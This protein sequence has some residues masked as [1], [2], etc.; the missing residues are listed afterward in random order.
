MFGKVIP[1]FG[2]LLFASVVGIASGV[3][4][5]QPWYFV[6][7][8]QKNRNNVEDAADSEQTSILDEEEVI[9]CNLD[10]STDK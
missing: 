2:Q 8:S 6:Q 1:P 10:A 4:I 9:S 3:Y 5:F 7:Y